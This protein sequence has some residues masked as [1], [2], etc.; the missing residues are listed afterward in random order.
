MEYR[1]YP[2]PPA[3]ATHVRC[4]W[5]LRDS[6]TYVDGAHA[7]AGHEN[8]RPAGRSD[9]GGAGTDARDGDAA[10]P[11]GS[12]ELIINLGDPFDH[13]SLDGRRIPQPRAFL[14]GQ[15]TRPFAVQPTGAVDL[16]AVRF[17][18]HGAALLCDDLAPLTDTWS[19][20]DALPPTG[21]ADLGIALARE[22]TSER[23]VQL[24]ASWL[25]R[26]PTQRAG[27]DTRVVAAVE[28]I[29]S[30]HGATPLDALARPLGI[31]SRT[32]QRLFAKQVGISPKLLARI[33]R[34]QHVLR[35]WRANPRSFARAAVDA[36]YYDQSHLVRDFRDFA[37]APPAGL[38]AALPE[39]TALFLS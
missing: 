29:R 32:L 38:L 37:G 12:P 5:T 1:E 6:S 2:P 30:S 8:W 23:R 3:A 16:V 20:I 14:V 11:D 39:F 17:E 7:D 9:S 26:L 19:T 33:V 34:F 27:A 31:S 22:S 18:A 35:A 13:I 4:I 36:A 15:I 24:T 28:A 10:L 25:A 21:I